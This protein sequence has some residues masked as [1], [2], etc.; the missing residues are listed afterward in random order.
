MITLDPKEVSLTKDVLMSELRRIKAD[1]KYTT[2]E[3]EDDYKDRVI[4][5]A[6]KLGCKIDWPTLD[7]DG[8]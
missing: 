8:M 2:L 1:E 6:N 3:L 5:L 7:P 4:A